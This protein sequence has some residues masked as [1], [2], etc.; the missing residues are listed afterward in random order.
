M[1]IPAERNVPAYYERRWGEWKITQE[2][3][4]HKKLDSETAEW[5]LTLAAG[6]TLTPSYAVETYWP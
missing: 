6:H 1:Q 4:P 3:A 2:S 5:V